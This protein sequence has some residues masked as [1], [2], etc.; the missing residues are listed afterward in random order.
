MPFVTALVPEVDLAGGRVVIADRPGLVTP[1][2]RGLSEPCASTTS[3]SSPTTSRR[4]GCRSPARPPTQGLVEVHV[5]DLRDLDP[6]PAP[7]RRRHA[8]RRRRRHGDEAR[9]VGRGVRRARASTAPT[10]GRARRRPGAPFTQALAR[11]LADAASGW[12]S[13]AAATRASTSGCSTTPRPGPRCVEVSLGDYVL[14]GGEVAALAVTEAVVRLLPGLHGQR[15]VAGRGVPRGRAAG[16]PRLHPAGVLARPRRPAGAARPATTPRSRPG[17]ADAGAAAYG[18]SGGPTCCTPAGVGGVGDRARA[19]AATPARSS[20]CSGPA[21]CRRRWPTTPCD[22]PALHE[23]LEDVWRGWT[24]GRPGWSA[25]A[26]RLVGAVRGR[27]EATPATRPGT[28][29][30]SW[31]P[32][33]SR[34]AGWAGRCSRTSRRWRRPRRRRTCCSPAP[35]APTTSGCTGRPATACARDLA[36]AAGRRDPDQAHA[37]SLGRLTPPVADSSLGPVGRRTARRRTAGDPR[38]APATGGARR[39]RPPATEPHT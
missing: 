14:N 23:S 12:C 6:R 16:V 25:V 2:R 28:S 31:S 8:V 15:R 18:A 5:H 20:P 27:L 39:R 1:L 22:I 21:G 32:P 26:G 29:A 3:R 33:T 36:G 7:H 35:A 9:A 37:D 17:G 11:E 13:R 4:C 30:G 10:R 24:T 19:P 34:A 38:R